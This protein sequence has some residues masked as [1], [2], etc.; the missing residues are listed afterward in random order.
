MK[1]YWYPTRLFLTCGELFVNWGGGTNNENVLEKRIL[2]PLAVPNL[3]C[4]KIHQTLSLGWSQTKCESNIRA[5]KNDNE[6]LALF[7]KGNDKNVNYYAFH[8]Y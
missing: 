7:R 8:I 4:E 6:H 5:K 1:W 3:V 2:S